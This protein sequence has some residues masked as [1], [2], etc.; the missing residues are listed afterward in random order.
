MKGNE[1]IISLYSKAKAKKS[2]G[3]ILINLLMHAPI[4]S[5]YSQYAKHNCLNILLCPP[6]FLKSRCDITNGTILKCIVG[7]YG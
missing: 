1:N 7:V 4:I 3:N 5:F 6:K 2:K